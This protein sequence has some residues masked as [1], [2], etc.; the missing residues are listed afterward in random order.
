MKIKIQSI[1]F[2]ADKK[3]LDHI[4]GKVSKLNHFHDGILSGDVILR[5]EKTAIPENKIAEIRLLIPGSDLFAKKQCKTFEEAVDT[6]VEAL[7]RQ[8]KKHKEKV[9]K[10]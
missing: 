3:L 1:H 10:I 4:Q 7:T 6:G 2:D 5:V 8:V 9:K